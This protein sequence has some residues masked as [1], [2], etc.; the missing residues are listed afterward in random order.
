M[1][2][3]RPLLGSLAERLGILSSYWDLT[4]QQRVT[5]DATREALL[6]A[7]H[8]DASD[9]AH[10]A[11]ALARLDAEQ[12][13]RWIDPVLVWR[14]HEDSIPRVPVRVPADADAAE[15]RLEL[16]A[17]NG[18]VAVAE[19]R[20]ADLIV[21]RS[22]G[23]EVQLSLPARPPLGYHEVRF[24]LEGSG[25]SYGGVQRFVMAPWTALPVA[26][27]LAGRR[28]FGLWTNLYTVRGNAGQGVGDLSDLGE[29]L[30]WCAEAGGAFV[31]VNPLHAVANR[32]L[33]ITPYSPSS[34]LF[35]NVLM[36][37][38]EAVPE[39]AAC[40][41]ARARLVE[42][43]FQQQLAALRA[44]ATIDHGAVL[45]A[46]LAVLRLLHACF[47]RAGAAA[48]RAADFAQFRAREGTALEDFATWEVLAEHFGA[49]GAP[50]CDWRHWPAP[51]RD[52]RAPAVAEFRRTQ[53]AEVE[54]RAW[55][56][57]ELDAQLARA[58]ARG[59]DAGLAIG[60]Y[61]DLAVGS[62]PDSAD[63]WMAQDLVAHGATVGAPPDDYAPDGQNWGF[64]PLDPHRLRADGY[65]LWS[66][67][68]RANL[69]HAGALRIDHAMGLQRLFWIPDGQPGHAGA[70]VKSRF[71]EMLG[72]LALESRRAG[73]LIIAEDLGTVPE[74]FRAQLADWSI[75]SSAVVYFERADGVHRP[76]A[77]YPIDAL[78]TVQ[79]HDLVP[80]AGHAD[81]AD[82]RIRR[83]A[84]QLPDDDALMRALAA[85]A[86]E[87]R[88]L[89][90]RL[91]ADG[92]LPA[93]GEVD[94]AALARAVHRFLATTRSVLVAASLDDLAFETEPV[95]VPGISVER[96]RSW[97]RRMTRTLATLRRDPVVQEILAELHARTA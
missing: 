3:E 34:R 83:R 66:R 86:D 32:G 96:H 11:A 90:D 79:T 46:K 89:L 20:V 4:G 52:P 87:H 15:W 95:N 50:A 54:F 25:V 92:L 55:L 14:E 19:G 33:A 22:A 73:A 63:T 51:Y 17:E 85:R 58:S 71:D 67:L 37:D 27:K 76:A 80:L 94:A 78:A 47:R 69:A 39:L 53:G 12:A 36:L 68:L 30:A 41:E 62:A 91:R 18:P 93:D 13:A 42:P 56:Q 29:L 70:Y 97:S 48:P 10:A 81:G 44:A 5:S 38:V 60:V 88:A 6:A 61:Q 31:G 75:L 23:S 40:G 82:L 64:P 28:A 24:F 77:T 72:V 9:E 43:G 8:I 74:A 16:H 65:R 59:R 49:P 84:G 7:L 57:F 2:S 26:E 35:R 45:D 21:D 1:S